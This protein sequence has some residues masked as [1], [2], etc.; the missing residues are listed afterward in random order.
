MPL[1]SMLAVALTLRVA[2]AALHAALGP[3]PGPLFDERP[4]FLVARALVEEGRFAT[5]PGGPPDVIRGPAYPVFLVPFYA[6][7]GASVLG[8]ALAQAALG[9]GTVWIVAV[10]VRRLLRREGASGS[11]SERA[12]SLA[13]WACALSPIAIAWDRFVMSES[14][15]TLLMAATIALWMEALH[16]QRP[17]ARAL[18]AGACGAA[19]VL[20][21]PAFVLLVPALALLLAWRGRAAPGG[22]LVLAAGLLLLPW[23][24]RNAAVAH[25][26]SP[27]GLGSGLFL[28]AATLPRASDGV[29][30]ID[31][32]RDRAAAERY[33][34]YDTPVDERLAADADFRRRAL[35]RIR[36]RPLA[37]LASW[38]PRGLRLWVSSHSEALRP[39]AV[40]RPLRVAIALGF[41]AVA[42]L[43]VS[44]LVLPAGPERRA[45][46]A[47]VV[48]PAY[49]TLVHMPLSSGSRYSVVAWPFVWS[50]AA[51]A[52]C[53]RTRARA[54][55]G[56]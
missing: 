21:K 41:G 11:P 29:P 3:G 28:Y 2:A 25:R 17:L 43:A 53:A 6:V 42:L 39:L 48:A 34:G 15:A 35:L 30:V 38:V 1:R 31:D 36:E 14:L 8:P 46:L 40:P 9:T 10:A 16:G 13:G 50:L 20:A 33:L 22:A 7:G 37:Y 49:T 32:P 56:S 12:A 23:T 19:L 5:R 18:A 52:F 27:A 24:A 4:F 55:L 26:A 45:A 44:A 47:L 54:P 51:L